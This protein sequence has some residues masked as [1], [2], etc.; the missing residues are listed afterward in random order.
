MK[1][2]THPGCPRKHRAKGYCAAHYERQRLGQSMETPVRRRTK[3]GGEAEALY[4]DKSGGPDACWPWTGAVS[5][6]YGRIGD[7]T[8]HRWMYRRH[9]GP[10]P[11]GMTVD[12]VREWGCTSTLCCNPAHLEAVYFGEN[13]RR[14]AEWRRRTRRAG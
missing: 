9:K 7:E 1:T 6:N 5:G 4:V 12:H 13:I 8:A 3:G 14:A 2:C 10:I 11:E